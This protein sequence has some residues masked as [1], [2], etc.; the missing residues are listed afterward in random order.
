T[1]VYTSEKHGSD[2]NGDGSEGKP[3]KTP[4][5]AYRKHGDNATVYVDG[6]DEAKDKWE[7][8]SKAQSKK[9]KTLYE[10]EKRKE[11]AAAEREEKEQQQ[12]EKNLE[13]A[14]KIIISEDTSLAKAKAV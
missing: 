4:L 10:S 12:R 1:T 5:Q 14:R 3:F 13:E 6:K 9:V 8:L 2:E 7:L 11:K